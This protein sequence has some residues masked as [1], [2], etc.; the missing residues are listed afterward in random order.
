MLFLCEQLTSLSATICLALNYCHVHVH[1]TC[2]GGETSTMTWFFLS[3]QG[4]NGDP[5]DP[6]EKGVQG[7]KGM[8]GDKGEKGQPGPIG[9]DGKHG[10]NGTDGE[11][12]TKGGKGYRGAFG[13]PGPPGLKGEKGD[14]VPGTREYYRSLKW[15]EMY[16]CIYIHV[17]IQ[18]TLCS[19]LPKGRIS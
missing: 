2:W 12:G 8:M 1:I 4:A 17:L 14:P 13:Q 10:V 18:W 19:E 3:A 11:K 6:G 7:P 5:G 9:E 15:V 16:T